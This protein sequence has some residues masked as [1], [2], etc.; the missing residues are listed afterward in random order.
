MRTMNLSNSISGYCQHCSFRT[1]HYLCGGLGGGGS[2]EEGK[3]KGKGFKLLKGVYF[4]IKKGGGHFFRLC[5][6]KTINLY[7]LFLYHQFVL[8]ALKV[9]QKVWTE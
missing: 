4:F 7:R 2:G 8:L 1:G 6:I 9:L 5:C 3:K